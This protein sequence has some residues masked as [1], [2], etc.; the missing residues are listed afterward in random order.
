MIILSF[1]KKTFN[2]DLLYAELSIALG[3]FF[4]SVNSDQLNILVHIDDNTPQ[5]QIDQVAIIVEAHDHT[6]FTDRQ[7]IEADA[8]VASG[9]LG[10][11]IAT[12][13]Q[14]HKDNPVT[15]LSTMPEMIDTLSRIQTEWTKFMQ[16]IRKDFV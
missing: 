7:V 11:M 6:L 3:T 14:W 15:E 5:A 10:E 2:S 16:L 1:D 8:A 9:E 4:L 12:R 13:I